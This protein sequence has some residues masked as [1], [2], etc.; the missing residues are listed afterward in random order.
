MWKV[1]G[2]NH[3]S[4]AVKDLEQAIESAVENMG[5]ELMMKFESVTDKY[6]GACIA[7]GEHVIS[8]IQATG[9]SS[10]HGDHSGKS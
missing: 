1:K 3:I 9:R 2:I 8:Y 10:T 6:I 4:F 5:G 7:L